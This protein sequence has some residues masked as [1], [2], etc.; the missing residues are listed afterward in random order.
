AQLSSYNMVGSAYTNNVP[1]VTT[2]TLYGIDFVADTLVVQDPAAGTVRTVGPLGVDTQNLVGF[3]I[4]ADG[5]AVASLTT[6]TGSGLY[7][8]NLASG[9]ATLIAPT[10][11]PPIIPH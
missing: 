11:P 1:G 2:T 5:T 4:T 8:I 10:R 6:G 3:D 9:A 7:L